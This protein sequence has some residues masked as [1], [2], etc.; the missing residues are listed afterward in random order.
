M[1]S[2]VLLGI[3]ILCSCNPSCDP[4]SGLQVIPFGPAG[5]DI[6]ITATPLSQLEGKTFFF[7]NTQVPESDVKMESNFLKLKIPSSLKVGKSI[8]KIQDPDCQDVVQ[9]NF[10]IASADTFK[11]N[12][13]FVMPI[14]PEIFIPNLN[15]NS[16]PASINKAWV[17]PTNPDYCL[18]FSVKKDSFPFPLF[19]N[20]WQ[21]VYS[22]GG[23]SFELSSCCLTS[24]TNK[25]DTTKCLDPTKLYSNNPIFGYYDIE[26]T[27]KKLYFFIDRRLK[28]GDIEEYEGIFIDSKTTK[29]DNM[30]LNTT[31]SIPQSNITCG[32]VYEHAQGNPMLLVTSKKT[33]KQ[34]VVYQTIKF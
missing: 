16:F 8:L 25:A 2:V 17:H 19:P 24:F 28:K 20:K 1:I 32:G 15:F 4:I 34:T 30:V 11:N 31:P 13:N 10:L 29:Y 6:T 33:G 27:P 5:Y 3:L 14:L 23:G 7:D 26:A 22:L 21:Y 18:W 9:I 12:I